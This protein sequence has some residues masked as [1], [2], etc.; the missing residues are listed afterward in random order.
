MEY[1]EY[2]KALYRDG[3]YL[4]VQDPESEEAARQDGYDDWA[5]DNDR[6]PAAADAE[7]A[8]QDTATAEPDEA[9]TNTEK[10]A[11]ATAPAAADPK[12]PRTYKQRAKK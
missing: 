8:P 3:I 12:A 4:E 9:A 6:M 10:T 1:I 11:P 7:G 2:P 5:A